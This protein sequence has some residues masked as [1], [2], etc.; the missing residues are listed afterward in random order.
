MYFPLGVNISED[1]R[2]G[3]NYFLKKISSLVVFLG[4]YA[5]E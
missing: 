2:G 1:K 5:R 4:N 3:G